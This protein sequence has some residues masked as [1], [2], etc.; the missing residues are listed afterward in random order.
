MGGLRHR[1]VSGATLPLLIVAVIL[2]IE[3]GSH[4]L[5]VPILSVIAVG[6]LFGSLVGG[7]LT[8]IARHASTTG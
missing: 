4:V 3:G 1:A 5:I 6:A 2:W 7:A 8:A